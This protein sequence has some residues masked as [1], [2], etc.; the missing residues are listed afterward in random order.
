MPRSCRGAAVQCACSVSPAARRTFSSTSGKCANWGV[1]DAA[2]PLFSRMA[3]V[4]PD[5][6]GSAHGRARA[7]SRADPRMTSESQTIT[8]TTDL[9]LS[10]D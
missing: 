10:R 7:M 6:L 3:E 8:T 9:P 2:K 1:R 5:P 4:Q